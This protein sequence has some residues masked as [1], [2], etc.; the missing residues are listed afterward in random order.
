MKIDIIIT[1]F[2]K[3]NC[4]ILKDERKKECLIIDPG[5]AYHKIKEKIEDYK[6][7]KILLTHDHF[8]HIGALDELIKENAVEVLKKENFAEKEYKINNFVF[9]V[10]FTPGHTD[11]S[12]SFYFQN[13]KVLFTG[14]FLFKGTIGRTD[15]PTGNEFDMTDSLKKIKKYNEDITIYPGHGEISTLKKEFKNNIYFINL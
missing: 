14:D 1:G 9:E 11:D 2:L 6:V 12:I 7:L 15:L 10:I 3:E 4:Y 5:D 13:E 8:D